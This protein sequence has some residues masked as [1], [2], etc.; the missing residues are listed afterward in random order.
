MAV[1]GRID[2]G[3]GGFYYAETANELYECKARGAFRKQR[4]T[5]LVGDRVEITVNAQGDNT[6]D[7]ILPRKNE[8]RR[9]LWPI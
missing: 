3:I 6:I 4:I 1:T 7:T 9:L 5:P 8:L 2:K